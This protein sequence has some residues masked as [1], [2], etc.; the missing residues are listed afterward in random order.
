MVV[1]V[2]AAWLVHFFRTGK[3]IRVFLPSSDGIHQIQQ[4]GK[5]WDWHTADCIDINSES[6]KY[7]PTS[8]HMEFV[9]GFGFYH[10]HAI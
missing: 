8:P 5:S 2:L 3:F 1:V 10:V 7:R 6:D 9:D 4:E